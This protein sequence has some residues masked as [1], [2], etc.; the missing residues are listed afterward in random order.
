MNSLWELT[1]YEYHTFCVGF[2]KRQTGLQCVANSVACSPQ[3]QLLCRGEG[4]KNLYYNNIALE[5]ILT[6]SK[7]SVAGEK[8]AGWDL[9]VDLKIEKAVDV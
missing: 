5:K 4:W 2:V 1:L 9:G 7:I 8:L 3:A 6:S